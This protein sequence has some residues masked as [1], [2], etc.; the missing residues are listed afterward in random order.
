MLVHEGHIDILHAPS[1]QVA[2]VNL[3]RR[4]RPVDHVRAR[5]ATHLEPRERRP[6]TAPAAA[7]AAVTQPG[8]SHTHFG[9][10]IN[11]RRLF[12]E[13]GSALSTRPQGRKRV[14]VR[15]W[16]G[17]VHNLSWTDSCCVM[18]SD[19]LTSKCPIVLA[20]DGNAAKSSVC[21]TRSASHRY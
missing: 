1:N 13:E 3:E 18:S 4:R 8:A 15:A 5:T 20:P 2:G 11:R 6:S 19:P 7:I 14:H 12:A 16:L 9:N 21:D 10:F 17:R